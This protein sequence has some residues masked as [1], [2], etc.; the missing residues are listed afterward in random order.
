MID[1]IPL[2]YVEFVYFFSSIS[3][4]YDAQW[5]RLL[6]HTNLVLFSRPRHVRQ[7]FRLRSVQFWGMIT[8][9]SMAKICFVQPIFTFD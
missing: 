2:Y 4:I 1:S 8:R 3:Q 7:I 5:D 6:F 9:L